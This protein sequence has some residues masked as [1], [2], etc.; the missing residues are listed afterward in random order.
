[1]SS[2][3]LYF[4]ATACGILLSGLNAAQF[5][6]F[7][8]TGHGLRR[9]RLWPTVLVTLC[10]TASTLRSICGW[11]A[12]DAMFRSALN[13]ASID[14]PLS[15]RIGTVSGKNKILSGIGLLIYLVEVAAC[16]GCA[17]W[18]YSFPKL[19]TYFSTGGYWFSFWI[20]SLVAS[21]LYLSSTFC[22]C[23]LRSR[24]GI[25]NARLSRALRSLTSVAIQASLPT[26]VFSLAAAIL[27]ITHQPEFMI[28][29]FILPPLY[30][31]AFL[32]TLNAR[33]RIQN[34]NATEEE[35]DWVEMAVA[36][37]ENG[38]RGGRKTEVAVARKDDL[39]AGGRAAGRSGKTVVDSPSQVLS[40]GG[41]FSALGG[42]GRGGAGNDGGGSRGGGRGQRSRRLDN[43][44]CEIEVERTIEYGEPEAPSESGTSGASETKVLDPDLYVQNWAR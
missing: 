35:V 37:L 43:I 20:W 41:M 42:G 26:V 5:G 23:I 44:S 31:Y 39:E 36:D 2:D 32:S 13:D 4:H 16:I 15:V 40:F 38:G 14:T 3:R 11:V 1:M 25:L 19:S 7:V 28:M 30:T 10:W 17:K 18:R 9:E 22:V 6:H 12:V 8:W 27:Y 34:E 21:E 33:T 29:Q 24:R